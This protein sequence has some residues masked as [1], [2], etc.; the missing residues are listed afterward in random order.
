[1]VEAKWLCQ[2]NCIDKPLRRIEGSKN[3]VIRYKFD[4]KVWE[5]YIK[6]SK[7][8]VSYIKMDR[9]TQKGFVLYEI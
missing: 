3:Y 5:K 4:W 7:N 8:E 6:I 1:M 9:G 2:R